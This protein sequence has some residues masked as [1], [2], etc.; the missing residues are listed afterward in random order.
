MRDRQPPPSPPE[1]RG[2][3]DNK[4]IPQED[5][6]EVLDAD[7]W[8]FESDSSASGD[9]SSPMEDHAEEDEAMC[10]FRGHA[11]SEK[12]PPL[13]FAPTSDARLTLPSN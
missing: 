3:P 5:V 11:P 6:E 12:I 8:I 1:M 2:L 4:M 9:E 13:I 7:G 10:V